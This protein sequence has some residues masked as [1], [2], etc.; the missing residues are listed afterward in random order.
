M[1]FFGGLREREI[2][3]VLGLSHRTVQRHWVKAR[4]WLYAELYPES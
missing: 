1:R 3:E 4:A 2:A